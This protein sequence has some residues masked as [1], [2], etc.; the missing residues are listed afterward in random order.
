MASIRNRGGKWQVQIRRQGHAPL[1]KTFTHY[2]D[3]TRWARQTESELERG[4]LAPNIARLKHS[5]HL[6]MCCSRIAHT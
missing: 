3:A 2:K 5:T 4:A 1:N 6:A